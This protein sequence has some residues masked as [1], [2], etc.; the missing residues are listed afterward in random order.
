MH[1]AYQ[2]SPNPAQNL[3]NYDNMFTSYILLHVI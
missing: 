1:L 2:N 3:V